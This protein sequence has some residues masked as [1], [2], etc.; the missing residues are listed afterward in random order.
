MKPI[1][2]VSAAVAVALA[3]GSTAEAGRA[4][5]PLQQILGT[6]TVKISNG[7]FSLHARIND[8]A[9]AWTCRL[10]FDTDLNAFTGWLPSRGYEYMGVPAPSP[11]VDFPVC[12][13]L[14][15]SN[16][17]F[18]GLITGRGSED[19]GS[20]AVTY[21]VPLSTLGNDDGRLAWELMV[22]NASGQYV[23]SY[24]GRFLQ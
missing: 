20:N 3:W 17:G 10:Y 24:A 12:Q 4:L 8:G 1:H 5:N 7:T 11:A 6:P 16:D 13:C 2:V 22:F 23:G 15:D 18:G 19:A 9:T 21:D 14:I